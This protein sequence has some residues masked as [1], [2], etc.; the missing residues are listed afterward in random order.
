M[1]A[2]SAHYDDRYFARQRAEALFS[3]TAELPKFQPFIKTTD[4][5]VDLG[6][7]GGFLLA[8][9]RCANRIGVDVNPAARQNCRQLD[10]PAVDDLTRIEDRWA[11]VVVSNHA[12]EH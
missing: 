8:K 5:V 9:L 2:A 11:D 1:T 4:A 6:C 7:G 10:L 3:G 12:L